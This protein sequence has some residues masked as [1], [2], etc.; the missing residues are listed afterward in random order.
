MVALPGVRY[1]P[2]H[3]EDEKEAARVFYVATTG[4]TQRLAIAIGGGGAFRGRLDCT[5]LRHTGE[6][7]FIA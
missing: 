7:Q 4:A 1:M 3:G 5:A 2:A 6:T